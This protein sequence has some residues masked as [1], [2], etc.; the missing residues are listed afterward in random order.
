MKLG[1]I[2]R[3]VKGYVYLGRYVLNLLLKVTGGM[4]FMQGT[5]IWHSIV[6]V[7]V[8]HVGEVVYR[9]LPMFEFAAGLGHVNELVPDLVFH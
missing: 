7:V 6:V 4:V 8:V 2:G 1:G 5:F 3:L 9:F